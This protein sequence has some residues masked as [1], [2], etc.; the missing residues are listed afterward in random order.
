MWGYKER[1]TTI[2]YWVSDRGVIRPLSFKQRWELC[3]KYPMRSFNVAQVGPKRTSFYSVKR[4]ANGIWHF[5]SFGY[6]TKPIIMK[7][8]RELIE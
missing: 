6:F 8:I 5:G 3:T 2:E 1:M 7:I 4:D